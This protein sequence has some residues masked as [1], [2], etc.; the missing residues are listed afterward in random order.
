QAPRYAQEGTS[1]E[2]KVIEMELKLI[3]DI[4]I[5][6][7][8]N[9]GKSTLLAHIT[10][11]KPKIANYPF[12]T[13]HPNLG[14]LELTD[15]YITIADIPGLIEGAHQG[16]GLG[17]E[18]LRHIERTKLL[19]H[20]VD[21]SD[22]DPLHKYE[23]INNELKNYNPE[24]SKKEQIL[25]LNKIDIPEAVINEEMFSKNETILISAATGEGLD[26][27]KKVLE[28]KTRS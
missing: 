23:V 18:F 4:G 26:N 3:A 10:A 28:Q 2:E 5:I 6:G 13:L 16:V 27:L 20:V 9:A 14:V 8:P 1:C 17:D 22:E 21:L 25:I 15:K 12:T 19:L 7:M 24:L 11:A